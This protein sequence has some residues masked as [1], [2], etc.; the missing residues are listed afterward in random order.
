MVKKSTSRVRKEPTGTFNLESKFKQKIERRDD[1]I[2]RKKATILALQNEI[3]DLR[4]QNSFEIDAKMKKQRASLRFIKAENCD[5][6]QKVH[7]LTKSTKFLRTSLFA[8]KQEIENMRSKKVPV[9]EVEDQK[10][11]A[12][13]KRKLSIRNETV[14][15]AILNLKRGK[16]LSKM[17]FR[18]QA[19]IRAAGQ[20][21]YAKEIESKVRRL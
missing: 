6:H 5:L 21:E 15:R 12:I 19:A 18:T 13:G 1:R 17:Q 8:A 7:E 11:L 2:K 10:A 3:V 4:N 16:S 9:L 20:W 14:H